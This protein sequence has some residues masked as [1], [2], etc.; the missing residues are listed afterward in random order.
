MVR[1]LLN[2]G[3]AA[4]ANGKWTFEMDR[5]LSNAEFFQLTK[6]SFTATTDLASP[7]HCVYV[8]SDAIHTLSGEKHTQV[9][10]SIHVLFTIRALVVRIEHSVAVFVADG[11]V[12]QAGEYAKDRRADPA[13]EA[14]AAAEAPASSCPQ[15]KKIPAVR[16]AP[17]AL[18]AKSF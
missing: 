10:K 15:K 16:A 11:A 17:G 5:R 6:C 13:G 9:L 18:A 7:P 2:D 1:F 8:R 3:N 12:G 4:F 14:W